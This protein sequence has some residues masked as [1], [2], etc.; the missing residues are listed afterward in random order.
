MA[1]ARPRTVLCPTAATPLRQSASR[2]STLMYST[3]NY[4]HAHTQPTP[5]RLQNDSSSPGPS[6]I[7]SSMFAPMPT[8]HLVSYHALV[9]WI[10]TDR[11]SIRL[12][13]R[14]RCPAQALS[15]A[16]QTTL[17]TF[18]ASALDRTRPTFLVTY[19]VPCSPSRLKGLTW[20]MW[21][22]IAHLGVHNCPQT[23]P[24]CD[25]TY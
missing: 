7:M 10:S 2:L 5:T 23:K 3:L 9:R 17:A 19:R 14:Q 24:I 18:T 6:P 13:L 12:P 4:R 8:P 22:Q 1:S 11:V 25:D 21:S 20:F 15:I 16:C